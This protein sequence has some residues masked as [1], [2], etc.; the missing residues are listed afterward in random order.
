[1]YVGPLIHL[2]RYVLWDRHAG[3]GEQGL[4]RA[5]ARKTSVFCSLCQRLRIGEMSDDEEG[6][7]ERTLMNLTTFFLVS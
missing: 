7:V 5:E 1:M 3:R 4:C 6:T 2:S